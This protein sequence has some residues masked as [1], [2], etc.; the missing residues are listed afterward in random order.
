MAQETRV[1]AE[2]V[3]IFHP[4]G[5]SLGY[6]PGGNHRGQGVTVADRLAQGHDVRDHLLGLKSPEFH[7]GPAEAHLD[8]V[9][10][11]EPP[12]PADMGK[13]GLHVSLGQDH[14]APAAQHGF[15]DKGGRSPAPGRYLLHGPLHVFGVGPLPSPGPCP[16]GLPYSRRAWPRSGPTP[17]RPGRRGRRA[18]RGLSRS[19]PGCVP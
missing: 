6:G 1:S 10:D 2:G 8:L 5:K 11:A 14:L 19:G 3:E 7:P 12:G 13:G 17:E 18:C 4:V 9:G 16:C 15:A